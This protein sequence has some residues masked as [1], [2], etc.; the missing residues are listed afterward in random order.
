MPLPSHLDNDP[1]PEPPERPDDDACCRSGCD[2]CIFD[3]YYA[4]MERWRAD[5]AAW[6]KRKSAREETG[7]ETAD[8]GS[9]SAPARR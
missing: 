9:G 2:P 7:N 4:E 6:E 8:A 5:L 1:R 3:T